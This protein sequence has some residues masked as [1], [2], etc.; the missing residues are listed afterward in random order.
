[1]GVSMKQ[2]ELDRIYGYFVSCVARNGFAYTAQCEGDRVAVC[3]PEG[4]AFPLWPSRADADLCISANWPAL[5][6]S[7]LTLREL[8]LE[9]PILG[10]HGIPVGVGRAPF[11]HGIL[12]PAMRLHADLVAA[13]GNRDRAP[14]A[15]AC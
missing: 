7:R 8:L 3:G 2:G 9:L 1:M 12:G 11:A 15:T 10:I 5:R 14:G 4:I 6:P 13:Q